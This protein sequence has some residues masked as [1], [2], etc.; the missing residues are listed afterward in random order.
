MR[1]PERVIP[2][3][4]RAQ[5]EGPFYLGP[6]TFMKT[7]MLSE[8][9][10][11]DR[12]Q[13]DV[14]II[15]APWDDVNV[16]RTGARLGPRAVRSA[17]YVHPFW[18]LD[19]EVAP[20]DELSV[21]DYGDAVCAPGLVGVSHEAIR[22]RV[23]EVARRGIFPV[24]IGGD[25]S[26]TYPS[27]TAVASTVEGGTLGIVHFDAHADTAPDFFGNLA[28]HGSPMRRLIESGAVP[29]RNFV[30][31][32]LRGY[33]PPPDI[34]A[35]MHEQG[36]RWHLMGEL[37]DQGVDAVISKAIDEALDGP[38][39]IYISVDIDVVDPGFAPGTSAPEPGGMVPADLFRAL[40]R[41]VSLTDVV[42]LDV[43]EVSPPYD[44]TGVT[45]QVANR[46]ILEVI[47]SLAVKRRE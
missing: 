17:N 3:G 25:H 39:R 45:A 32:G 33:W 40:R 7:P 36:M 20:F 30:Q 8:P 41:L 5:M 24:V 37:L 43:V 12:W 6:P 26:I 18:H 19:L 22:M 44:P 4:L 35:W 23:E 13:P 21:I 16:E 28:S 11:L 38:D 2:P 47:S 9:E 1:E 14:A 42:A 27:A 10:D 46:C 15:G 31:V 34:L 29:G